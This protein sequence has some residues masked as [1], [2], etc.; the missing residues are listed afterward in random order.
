MTNKRDIIN[1]IKLLIYQE[2]PEILE[3]ISFKDENIFLNPLLFSY[4]NSKKSGC[5]DKEILTEILQGYYLKKEKLNIKHSFNKENIAY[6]PKVGY[7][8]KGKKKAFMPIEI[9]KD[10]SIEIIKYT[11]PLFATIFESTIKNKIDDNNF[12]LDEQLFNKN[13]EYLTNAFKYIKVSSEEHFNLIEQNCKKCILFKTNPENTNSFATIKAHGMAFFNV[14][15]KEY[16]EVFFVDDIAHQT[17]HIILNTILFERKKYFLI[18]ENENIGVITKIKSEYRSF[19][20]LFHAL[21]TYYTTLTCIDNCIDSKYFKERQLHEAKARIGFYLN[22]V[23]SDVYHF[24]QFIS[25]HNGIDF[26]LSDRG[27]EIYTTMEDKFVKMISKW[28]HPIT[29]NYDYSNQ[30][31]NFTYQAFAK[32]NSLKND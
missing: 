10:T 30:P 16:D 7:F 12:I 28:Y 23:I 6:I 29:K 13:I 27:I 25:F 24:N 17:G 18:D 15:Q 5:F 31:Y 9:I 26:V 3:K 4:F 14:Y 22:K 11:H 21:Y 2:V 1:T 8:K 32:L 20:I 19:Y